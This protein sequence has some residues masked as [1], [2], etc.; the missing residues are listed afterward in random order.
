MTMPI[1]SDR[2]NQ[3][4]QAWRRGELDPAA[5]G[6]LETR[7]FFEPELAQAAQLDQALAAG[8]A[9]L[10]SSP[11]ESGEPAPQREPR[12][13]LLLAAGLGAMAVL[14]LAFHAIGPAPAHANVEVVSIDVRRGAVPA[15]ATVSPGR[16]A[17]L[18]A[19]RMPAPTGVAAPLSV[20]FV[21]ADGRQALLVDH[22]RPDAGS[23]TLAF[24][25]DALASAVYRVEFR[26]ASEPQW[27]RSELTFRFEPAD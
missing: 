13:P 5:V 18:V 1:L 7:L 11:G 17:E 9:A 3:L 2:D 15:P 19:M 27:R 8:I 4:L 10:P 21:G 14:P 24:A 16:G 25:P 20:R 12:W 22:L 26:Q 6:A 23:V